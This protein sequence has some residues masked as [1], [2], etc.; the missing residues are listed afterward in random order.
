MMFDRLWFYG[1]IGDGSLL[2][3][4]KV[5]PCLPIHVTQVGLFVSPRILKNSSPLLANKLQ[6]IPYSRYSTQYI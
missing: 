5:H 3:L 4:I 1:N 6:S 2:A